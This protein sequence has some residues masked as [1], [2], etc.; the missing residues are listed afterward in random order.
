MYTSPSS[1]TVFHLPRVRSTYPLAPG[2][3][4]SPE[5]VAKNDP[6]DWGP[7]LW[8]YLHCAPAEDGRQ[9][10]LLEGDVYICISQHLRV[11]LEVNGPHLFQIQLFPHQPIQIDYHSRHSRKVGVRS[12]QRYQ[13]EHKVQHRAEF[14]DYS[15]F[16]HP[17][18]L[19]ADRGADALATR[20]TGVSGR[21][22]KVCINRL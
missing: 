10:L 2:P 19:S 3:N 9:C 20:S 21:R 22:C 12:S 5:L 13:F 14:V 4:S 18:S 6:R 1:N 11:R 8:Y 16:T 17:H 7:H 15:K